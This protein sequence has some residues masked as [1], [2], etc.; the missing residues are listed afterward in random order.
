M[1]DTVHPA[2]TS[3]RERPPHFP[4]V[5]PAAPESKPWQWAAD[6]GK[7]AGVGAAPLS[8]HRVGGEVRG[9][10]CSRLVPPAAL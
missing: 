10:I 7:S 1:V 6:L 4:G 2:L 9:Q 8:E 5:T 3:R